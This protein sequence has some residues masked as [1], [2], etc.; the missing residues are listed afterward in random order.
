MIDDAKKLIMQQRVFLVYE[1]GLHTNTGHMPVQLFDG[2]S[3][4]VAPQARPCFLAILNHE[5]E[6]SVITQGQNE[7]AKSL[8]A[9]LISVSTVN[10][11][12]VNFPPT[13][14]AGLS[15][16][17]MRLRP[18]CSQKTIQSQRSCLT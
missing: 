7:L 10:L 18:K 3:G 9:N 11:G 8:T 16:G 6:A 14:A 12:L 5:S 17:K 1:T 15:C 4:H 2:H 13:T